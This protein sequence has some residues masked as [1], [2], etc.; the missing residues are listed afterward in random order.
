VSLLVAVRMRIVV[1]Y[2]GYN[3]INHIAIITNRI[4]G[5]NAGIMSSR[6]ILGITSISIIVDA[7]T[8]TMDTIAAEAVADNVV[9]IAQVEIRSSM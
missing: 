1:N 2:S 9:I 6:V 7:V 8:V 3:W 4:M 5:A